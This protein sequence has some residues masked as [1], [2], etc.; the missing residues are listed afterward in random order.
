VEEHLERLE[1]AFARLRLYNL[2]LNGSKC[3]IL[4]KELTYYG[5]V[6]TGVGIKADV[7]KI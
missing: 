7:K 1:E 2:K 5:H 6:V 4:K 3:Q